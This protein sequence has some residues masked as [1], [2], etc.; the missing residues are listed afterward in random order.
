MSTESWSQRKPKSSIGAGAFYRAQASLLV[1]GGRRK[2]SSLAALA[3][4]LGPRHSADLSAESTTESVIRQKCS[5]DD[6]GADVAARANV[7]GDGLGI[8]MRAPRDQRP[9]SRA[10]GGSTFAGTIKCARGERWG[11][12]PAT[13]GLA[14]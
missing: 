5:S 7:E 14:V 12:G 3:P 8:S 2:R 13:R 10:A 1:S 9:G 4:A 11:I 6:F